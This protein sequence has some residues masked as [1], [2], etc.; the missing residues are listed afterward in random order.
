M[1]G[2]SNTYATPAANR[3]RI[4]SISLMVYLLLQQHLLL[5]SIDYQIAVAI[6]LVM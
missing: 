4:S 6:I 2:I 1:H 3:D 5:A